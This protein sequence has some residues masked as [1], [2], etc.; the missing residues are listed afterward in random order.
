MC[1]WNRKL[2]YLRQDC[3]QGASQLAISIWVIERD[4]PPSVSTAASSSNTVDIFVN[5]V[6]EVKVHHMLYIW[7]IQTTGSYRGCHQDWTFARAEVG[8]S[9]LSLPLLTVTATRHINK[10]IKEKMEI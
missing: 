10:C 3:D 6:G 9:L 8:Q 4:S 1:F 7:N 5:V 2:S